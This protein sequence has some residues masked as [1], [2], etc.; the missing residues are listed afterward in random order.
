MIKKFAGPNNDYLQ[1]KAVSTQYEL[2]DLYINLV[3][4]CFDTTK[5][6]HKHCAGKLCRCHTDIFA[7]VY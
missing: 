1:L 4:K 6:Q 5:I 7:P 2:N 3:N